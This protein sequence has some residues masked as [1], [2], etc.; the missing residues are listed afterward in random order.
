M[1]KSLINVL[2]MFLISWC[3]IY[4]ITPRSIIVKNT[5]RKSDSIVY[6]PGYI[7]IESMHV[8]QDMPNNSKTNYCFNTPIRRHSKKIYCMNI[9]KEQCTR[10]AIID[11]CYP[12]FPCP[13]NYYKVMKTITIENT[14]SGTNIL[15]VSMCCN[16][17]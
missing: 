17:K 15:S 6:C 13:N 2:C 5:I 10:D 4:I 11:N 7:H 3:I 16:M 14:R 1:T 9:P 8:V 12:S